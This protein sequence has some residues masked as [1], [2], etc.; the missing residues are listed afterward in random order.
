MSNAWE[1]EKTPPDSV[2]QSVL[3]VYERG[4]TIDAL[5]RAT[6]FAPLKDWVGVR[7]CCLASRIAMNAGGVRLATRLAARMWHTDKNHPLSQFEYG[8]QLLNRR[9]PLAFWLNSRTWP[10][11][12]GGTTEWQAEFLALK[13]WVVSDLRDFSAA[14]Q[15]INQAES[16]APQVPWVRLQRAHHLERLEKVEEALEIASAACKLHPHPFYRPGVQAIAHL[17]QLL[18]R[19]EEAIQLLQQADA[20]LQNGQM[21]VQLYSLLANTQH[22]SAAEQALERY[23]ILS[24]LLEPAAK[25]WLQ[26]QRAQVAYQLGKRTEAIQFARE[27]KDPFNQ[28]FSEKLAQPAPIIERVRFDVPFVRQ[29]F[30]TCAPATMAALGRYWKMPAEHLALVE[31]ICY[32]GT[33]AWQQRDWAER[34]GWLVREFRVTWESALALLAQGIPFAITTVEAT[35]AHM[36]AVMGFDQT[37]GTLL[38]RDPSQ[39]YC[40]ESHA[41]VFFERYRPF[42]PRGMV[43]LP[44]SESSR[45]NSISLPDNELYDEYHALTLALSKHDREK[46]QAVLGQLESKWPDH[47][48]TWEARL[49]LA[50]YDTNNEEQIRCLDHL[51]ELFPNN[52]ARLLRR[53]SCLRDATREERIDFLEKICANKNAD[54]A[55][56][57]EL[58]RNLMADAPRQAS[59]EWWLRRAF[60]WRPVDSSVMTAQAELRWLR[61]RFDEATELYRFAATVEGYREP[62]YQSWFAACR[63]VRQMDT[64]LAQLEDRF[65]R[66]G[67]RSPQPAL[68]LAWAL[69]EIEQPE[70]ARTILSEAIQLRPDDGYLILRAASLNARL[71]AREQADTL[72][73]LAKGKV[74]E[75][76]WLRTAAEIAEVR[77]DAKGQ[78]QFSREILAL[79]PLAVDAHGGVARSLAQ[80]EGRPVAVA[81]LKDACARHPHHCELQRLFIEWLR[82]VGFEAVITPARDFLKIS[83]RDAWTR[84]ELA[85][86]LANLNRQDEALAEAEEAQ[87]IEPRISASLGL[88]GHIQ[89]RFRHF[90]E[91]RE[92]FRQAIELSVDNSSAIAGLLRLSNTDRE[93]KEELAFV[94]RELIRQVVRGDGLLA[95]MEAARPLLEPVALLKI[96]QQAHADRPDLWH[97]W[98]ALVMQLDH[99]GR[100]DEALP[101]AR[102]ATERF[103]HLP[104]MWLDLATIHQRCSEAEAE[105]TAAQRAF[106]INPGWSRSA[107]ALAGALE[108][109]RELNEAKVVYERA[110]RHTPADPQLHVQMA[111]VLWRLRQPKEALVSI[112]NALRLASN[113]D[114][115]WNLLITWSRECGQTERPVDFARELTRDRPG[116]IYGWLMLAKVLVGAAELTNRL[117]AVDRAL[118]LNPHY[119][120]AWDLKAELLAEALQFAAAV[121]ACDKGV[122]ACATNSFM[123][124]GR[125]AWIEAQ[126]NRVPEAIREMRAVLAENAG[127]TWGWHQLVVWLTG[128]EAYAD[129]EGAIEQLLKL[130]PQDAWSQRQLALVRLKQGDKAGAQKVFSAVFDASPTDRFAAENLFN[131]Q[132]EISNLTGAAETLRRMQTHQPGARTLAREV[133]LNT[134]TG[135]KA[136][137]LKLFNTL[138]VQPDPDP[139]PVQA[140]AEALKKAGLMGK[141]LKI[142]KRA[143]PTKDCNLQVGATAIQFLIDKRQ[144]LRAVRLFGRIYS[145]ETRT[146]AAGILAKGLAKLDARLSLRIVLRRYREVFFKD[147]AA[148]GQV[149][150]ALAKF[151]RMRAVAEWLADWRSRPSAEPWM[152][153]NLCFALRHLGHYQQAN[154]VAEYAVQK[155]GYRQENG[156][157]LRLFLAVEKALAGSIDAAIENLQRVHARSNV[158]HDQQLLAITKA[159]VEFQQSPPEARRLQFKAIRQQLGTVFPAGKTLKSDR[160]VRRTLRRAGKVFVQNGAGQGANIWFFW[161]LNWQW[162]LLPLAPILLAVALFPPI[163]I[164]LAL[165]L[166]IRRSRRKR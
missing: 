158:P 101:L 159:L 157:D 115:A 76:D 97:A 138:C 24:P 162:S 78:L 85:W 88:L 58:A 5:K 136:T 42:G 122:A 15:L 22:W 98:S 68:T 11:M 43:F 9:G 1:T 4:Q 161:K 129:A 79:E 72:L 81:H 148:W 141:A 34:N 143:L 61:G 33:P 103:P 127:Y 32:D 145:P 91:A 155:W 86:A 29:H 118:E 93:R 99:L 152:L 113:A 89:E 67:G 65:R 40:L 59:A 27:L 69:R 104:R 62:L 35:S 121:E 16:L 120:E 82:E 110:L 21:A 154:E 83:P 37:R 144:S 133:I 87:R 92:H 19:D 100:Y 73:N 112:E 134:R 149:G 41:K 46:A 13:S 44:Q 146:R 57:V 80:L 96:L 163:L 55:L 47:A 52:P 131:L 30:K 7:G 139:W 90:P 142:L 114:W 102:K 160:D 106:E 10:T 8:I 116:D 45:L 156:A 132:L 26:S 70:K 23:A 6:E 12:T 124:R 60:R 147:D 140:A 111:S 84:R 108:R 3:E 14:D 165:G 28:Q 36:Q 166:L 51:L 49:D 128:Q 50:G 63:Q 38:L 75:N 125:R 53:L 56:F 18:D 130:Q 39:P 126:R 64:A 66:F 95:F 2:I 105:I 107:F 54:P 31:T 153:F 94:E 109:H 74:R 17:L 25:L 119:F 137:A 117:N 20:C 48:I 77:F 123:L 151:K 71:G 164:G 135:D 150:Y